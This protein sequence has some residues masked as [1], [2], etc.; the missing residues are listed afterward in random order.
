ML[1]D[2]ILFYFALRSKTHTN[3]HWM[4]RLLFN[5]EYFDHILIQKISSNDIQT[6]LQSLRENA[7]QFLKTSL[8]DVQ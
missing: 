6:K 4:H 7:A 2:M 3:P 8:L 1:K 5:D